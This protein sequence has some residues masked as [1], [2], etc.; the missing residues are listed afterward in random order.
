MNFLFEGEKAVDRDRRPC[1]AALVQRRLLD[2]RNQVE[3]PNH[4]IVDPAIGRAEVV[5]DVKYVHPVLVVAF[6]GGRRAITALAEHRIQI[7]PR[8]GFLENQAGAP[9]V[10]KPVVS[11]EL[12]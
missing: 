6:Q 2:I 4:A 3:S 11:Q 5:G 1:I 7:R 10:A 12:Q 9:G 8:F